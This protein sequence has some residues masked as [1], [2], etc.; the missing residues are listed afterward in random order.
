VPGRD[1]T[2]GRIGKTGSGKRRCE[3]FS[4][5][6]T[7]G[8]VAV[9]LAM[10]MPFAATAKTVERITVTESGYTRESAM[11]NAMQAAV[12]TLLDRYVARNAADQNT[13][14]ID[15]ILDNSDRY[16]SSIVII[17]EQ[18]DED[19]IVEIT[20]E[21]AVDTDKIMTTLRNLDIVLKVPGISETFVWRVR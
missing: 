9:L 12:Q 5:K 4:V 11:K 8:T 20:A 19:D 2:S 16:V 6:G 18:M 13:R 3:M 15:Q 14:L 1:R 7:V 21:A 10:F 17:D